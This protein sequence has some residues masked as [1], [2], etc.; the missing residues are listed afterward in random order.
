MLCMVGDA[1]YCLSA[2]MKKFHA[3]SRNTPQQAC[4][5]RD[6]HLSVFVPAIHMQSS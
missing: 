1:A 4:D 5:V 6:R 2:S 3:F